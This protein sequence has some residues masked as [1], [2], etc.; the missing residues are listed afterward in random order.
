MGKSNIGRINKAIYL[1]ANR[2]GN[3]FAFNKTD[4]VLILNHLIENADR[5]VNSCAFTGFDRE[6]ILSNVYLAIME[7]VE[8]P[9][10]A[11][12]RNIKIGHDQFHKSAW[13]ECLEFIIRAK[14]LEYCYRQYAPDVR[15]DYIIDK[16]ICYNQNFSRNMLMDDY[17]GSIDNMLDLLNK[18]ERIIVK[19]IAINNMS[20]YETAYVLGMDECEV[21]MYY[22]NA[23][24][25]LKSIFKDV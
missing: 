9:D 1:Q 3:I 11:R 12:V 25:K 23:I 5:I 14:A 24:K 22:N 13:I 21:D 20:K 7:E 16:D 6:E 19:S 17:R 10:I 15:I 2:K 4:K 18:Y 8:C